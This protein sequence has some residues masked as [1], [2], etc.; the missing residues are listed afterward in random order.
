MSNSDENRS[1]VMLGS[2]VDGSS[3]LLRSLV[4]FIHDDVR[5]AA[6]LRVALQPPQQHPR[7]AVQ[8]SGGGALKDTHVF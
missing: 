1:G 8:K 5:D 2:T 4:H 7:G 3:P 6:E